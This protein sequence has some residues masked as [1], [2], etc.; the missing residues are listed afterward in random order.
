MP[1]SEQAIRQAFQSRGQRCTSGCPSSETLSRLAAGE[2]SETERLQVVRSVADCSYCAVELKVLMETKAWTDKAST[3]FE[4]EPAVDSPVRPPTSAQPG[5]VQDGGR[6]IVPPPSRF[7]SIVAQPWVGALA[8][9]LLLLAVIGLLASRL[10]EP[11]D[12]PD[13]LRSSNPSSADLLPESDA[14]L[15]EPPTAFAWPPQVGATSYA[16]TLY[17]S[18]ANSIWQSAPT[19]ESQLQLDAQVQEILR[20]SESYFWT[21]NAEGPVRQSEL[22]PFWFH[23]NP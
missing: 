21:V 14:T 8:A 17:D 7:R 13:R 22:G 5:P 20:Q 19:E 9:G 12:L 2:L 11:E 23:I 1:L 15:E 6:L 4:Q 3:R 18:S 16:V 10:G